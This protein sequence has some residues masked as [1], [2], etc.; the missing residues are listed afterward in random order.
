MRSFDA[1]VVGAGPA[2]VSAALYLARFG[3]E[4]ALVEK[5]APGGLLLQTFEIENYPGFPKGVKGYELADALSDQL[6]PY[7]N[8]TR[9]YGEIAEMK[10][11]GAIKQL[12][13]DDEW[14]SAKAV[15]VSSG[16]RYRKL[17]LPGEDKLLGK[18]ISHCALCDGN[19]FRGQ[20][21]AVAGGGNS[22]IEESLHLAKIAAKLH[23]IHRRDAFRAAPVYVSRLRALPNVELEYS[24]VI[25]ALHGESKLEGVTLKRVQSGEEVFLPLD[26]LF[27]F[28]GFEPAAQFLPVELERDGGGFILTDTEMRTNM[29]G[30]FAAGDIRSKLC[31]QVVTAVGDGA[32]AANTAHSYLEQSH[33]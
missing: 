20:V 1:L 17:G 30:I 26:G 4:V 28:I 18:G 22:A 21:I 33:G 13:I 7:T 32:T 24:T 23:V 16:V 6:E 25:T 19:F 15:I 11:E 10:T 5:L 9:I 12:R 29:P 14:V 8:L 31:R 27:V 2:G 3:I